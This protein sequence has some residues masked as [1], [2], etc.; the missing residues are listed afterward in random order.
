MAKDK[1]ERLDNEREH[2]RKI[3]ENAEEIWGVKPVKRS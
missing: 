1:N 3:S 2:G